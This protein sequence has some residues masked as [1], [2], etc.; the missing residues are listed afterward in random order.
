MVQYGVLVLSTDTGHIGPNQYSLR[1]LFVELD[2]CETSTT[3]DKTL[4]IIPVCEDVE[5]ECFTL[6]QLVK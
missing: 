6:S 1:T 2:F 4:T 5:E 3:L